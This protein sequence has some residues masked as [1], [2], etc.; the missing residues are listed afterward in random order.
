MTPGRGHR[1]PSLLS[2]RR[3]WLTYVVLCGLWTT[4]VAW[5]ALRYG[6]QRPGEFGPAPHPLQPWALRAHAL[7]AFA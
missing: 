2:R 6:F 5:L 4:G 3:R 7:F 1:A